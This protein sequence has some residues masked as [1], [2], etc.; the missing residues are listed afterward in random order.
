MRRRSEIGDIAVYEQLGGVESDNRICRHAAIGARFLFF[1]SSGARLFTSLPVTNVIALRIEFAVN[2]ATEV[3]E[4]R[5]PAGLSALHLLARQHRP[6]REQ[7]QAARA[8]ALVVVDE[9]EGSV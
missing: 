4:R 1:R 9:F 5:P 7:P 3:H 2:A 8:R 6:G